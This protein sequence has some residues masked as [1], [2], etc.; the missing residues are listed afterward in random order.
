MVR[1]CSDPFH[2]LGAY[3]RGYSI[4][5]NRKRDEKNPYRETS[6]C[7]TGRAIPRLRKLYDMHFKLYE[8]YS[9]GFICQQVRESLL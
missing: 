1:L 7:G 3:N 5:L 2:V 9:R 4:R 8:R 6:T